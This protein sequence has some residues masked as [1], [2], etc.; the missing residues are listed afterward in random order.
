MGTLQKNTSKACLLHKFEGKTEP[1]R[2]IDVSY[3]HIFDGMAYVQQSRVSK[4]T[5]GEFAQNLLTRILS[6]GKNADR[7]GVVFG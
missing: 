5:F 7:I 3:A 2:E 4:T 1:V 6:I